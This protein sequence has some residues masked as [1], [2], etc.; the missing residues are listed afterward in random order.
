MNSNRRTFFGFAAALLAFFRAKAQPHASGSGV[1]LLARHAL[2]GPQQ[3]M[4]A[5]LV[6]VT[7]AAGAPSHIHRHPGFVLGYVLDGKL[8]FGINNETP[9][10][11]SAG[12]SFFEPIGA[13]HTTGE[14][15]TPG[16]PVRFLA[17]LVVPAGSSIVLPA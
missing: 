1:K 3:G 13:V 17:F 14:S 7:S 12:A 9:E 5:V 4:E 2:T 8:S 6:E 10:T 16:E 15:A 11:I